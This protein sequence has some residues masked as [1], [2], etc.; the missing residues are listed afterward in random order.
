MRSREAGYIGFLWALLFGLVLLDSMISYLV[1]PRLPVPFPV[2]A[3]LP[4]GMLLPLGFAGVSH[5][6]PSQKVL[7]WLFLS[8]LGFSLGIAILPELPL[9]R[10]LKILSALCAFFIGYNAIKYAVNE[11]AY[12]NVVLIVS[13]F[14]AVV[15]VSALLGVAPG[16]F[17]LVKA[18]GFREGVEFFRP[19][20]TTDQN[21]Q[22]FYL[23]PGLLA[24][25]IPLNY[26]RGG[27][28]FFIALA[29]LYS[30]AQLQTRSGIILLVITLFLAYFY[31]AWIQRR[32]I[33]WQ[34]LV[35]GLLFFVI[36]LVK[37]AAIVSLISDIQYRFFEDDFDTLWGRVHSATYL[38][39][40]VW[41]PLWWVP[42][43]NT[44]FMAL[45][46]GVKPHFSP[47]AFYLEGG[48]LSLLGWFALVLV[49]IV[50]LLKQS[51]AR[52]FDGFEL[53]IVVGAVIACIGTLSLNAPLHEHL[54]LWMGAAQGVYARRRLRMQRMQ[55]MQ[56]R[57]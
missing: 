41:N 35:V 14:Y 26:L 12:I 8:F 21:F 52:R 55:R 4:I 28:V 33:A 38:L 51:L 31:V 44:E 47:T 7:A 50:S 18:Y 48:L 17:P 34:S 3:L 54:W 29:A 56:R 37:Q 15:C 19:E 6:L 40:K 11:N 9:L 5:A 25:A 24:L 2:N 16:V 36:F 30:L 49:P 53:A 43:G 27:I 22:V 13:F 10:Y 42:Q 39:E 32:S 45:S 46:N 20:I 23:F 1:V 57:K